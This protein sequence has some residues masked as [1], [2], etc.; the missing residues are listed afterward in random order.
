MY[1]PLRSCPFCGCP[2]V[3]VIDKGNFSLIECDGCLGTFYQQEACSVEDNIE[4]WNKRA[5]DQKEKGD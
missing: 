5:N 2:S 3:R 1:Y 4:A